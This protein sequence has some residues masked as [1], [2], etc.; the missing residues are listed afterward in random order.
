LVYYDHTNRFA[1]FSIELLGEIASEMGLRF[2]VVNING[3]QIL[4]G[5]ADV[6]HRYDVGIA[7][8]PATA[9][10]DSSAATLEYLVGGLAILAGTAQGQISGP[11]SLC[12]LRVGANRGSAGETA[13]LRQNEGKCHGTPITYLPYDDDVKGPALIELPDTVVVVHPGQSARFDGF[14]KT[15]CEIFSLSDANTVRARAAEIGQIVGKNRRQTIHRLRQHQGKRIFPGTGGPSQDYRVGKTIPRQH[16]AQAMNDVGVTVE[17]GEAHK[18]GAVSTQH[19]A[20][21]HNTFDQA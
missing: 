6:A 14:G 9:E 10:L 20:F 7:S 4:P 13:V 18:V 19:S 16:I 15:G 2:G 8:Q 5:F 21:S 17:A 12:G 11:D 3:N 1:G